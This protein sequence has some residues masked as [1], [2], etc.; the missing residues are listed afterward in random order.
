MNWQA[1][2]DSQDDVEHIRNPIFEKNRIS[3][4]KKM[5]KDLCIP[6]YFSNTANH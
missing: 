1:N 3:Y 2:I 5:L 4:F 6:T